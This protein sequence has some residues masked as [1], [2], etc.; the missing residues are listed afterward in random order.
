MTAF[1]VRPLIMRICRFEVI[2]TGILCAS[3][4]MRCSLSICFGIF[5][6]N[7]TVSKLGLCE[8]I[9]VLT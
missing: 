5:I 2:T 7:P 3:S 8:G 9:I 4:K 1:T 6:T